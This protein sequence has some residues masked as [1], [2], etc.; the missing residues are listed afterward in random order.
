MDWKTVGN[1]AMSFAS[2]RLRKVCVLV[3]GIIVLMVASSPAHASFYDQVFS[4]VGW[5][6]SAQLRYPAFYYVVNGQIVAYNEAPVSQ[7]YPPHVYRVDSR[8][9]QEYYPWLTVIFPPDYR[10]LRWF[11]VTWLNYNYNFGNRYFPV[12]LYEWVPDRRSWSMKWS[13]EFGITENE[14]CTELYNLG[15]SSTDSHWHAVWL[16]LGLCSSKYND[17]LYLIYAPISGWYTRDGVRYSYTI[18]TY[19]QPIEIARPSISMSADRTTVEAG[20]S[21]R[22]RAVVRGWP[23]RVR[24][25]IVGP[26]FSQWVEATKIGNAQGDYRYEEWEA[27]WSVPPD[28]PSGQYT[29]RAV[30]TYQ[31]YVP[32]SD[33]T[34]ITI[35]PGVRG[36]CEVLSEFIWSRPGGTVTFACVDR[37]EGGRITEG[38]AQIGSD[39]F[40]LEDGDGD[41][42]WVGQ[43]RAPESP[44]MFT[45]TARMTARSDSGAE[46]QFEV[47]SRVIVVDDV[48]SPNNDDLELVDVPDG[49]SVGRTGGRVRLVK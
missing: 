10:Q 43:L 21:V 26:N 23:N 9:E 19:Y 13:L 40:V 45:V 47:W 44:G 33:E 31:L 4:Q 48:Q 24:F 3:G 29:V 6:P 16:D 14:S 34:T 41:G 39:M 17:G 46:H 20:G 27:V 42:V 11:R 12:T 15:S 49:G 38:V 32:I 1:A 25:Q 18:E 35:E 5:P 28:I 36:M 37:S 8:F 30:P 2:D 7:P 22:F